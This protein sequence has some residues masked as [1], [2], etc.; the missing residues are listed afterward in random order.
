MSHCEDPPDRPRVEVPTQRVLVPVDCNIIP[1]VPEAYVPSKKAP[2]KYW[3]PATVRSCNDVVV[4]MPTLPEKFAP[5][6]FAKEV[7]AAKKIGSASVKELNLELKVLQSVAKRYPSFVEEANP[8]LVRI[9]E[10]DSSPV[11][12][13]VEVP[14]KFNEENRPVEVRFLPRNKLPY[15]VEVAVVLAIVK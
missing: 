9:V 3:L 15:I 12:T 14:V 6:S 10:E 13:P 11:F 5:V 2:V 1:A 4:P 8:S 7:E